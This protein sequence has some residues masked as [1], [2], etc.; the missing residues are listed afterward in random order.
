MRTIS[1]IRIAHSL[2]VGFTLDSAASN[3][4][5]VTV[6]LEATGLQP[7]FDEFVAEPELASNVDFENCTTG[8]NLSLSKGSDVKILGHI[9]DNLKQT[10]QQLD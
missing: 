1:Y 9:R 7:F 2:L 10:K 8:W 4:T 3:D 5:R 6:L